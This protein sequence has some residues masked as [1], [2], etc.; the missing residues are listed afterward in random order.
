MQRSMRR[1]DRE[2]DREEALAVIDKCSFAVL[3]TVNPDGSPYTVP[4]SIAR[5][6]ELLYFHSAMEGHKI[7]NLKHDKRVS[8]CCVGDHRIVPEEF[9]LFYESAIV[10]GK[11]EEIIN[12]DE[13]IHA[14]K[15]ISLRHTPKIMHMFDA[16]IAKDLSRTSVW[17]ITIDE[18]SGKGRRPE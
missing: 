1:K 9:A 14:L 16:E 18:I 3:A 8:L 17:K 5:D 4:L 15:I 6:N 13:K 11:A 2:L 12:D 10:S 7:D